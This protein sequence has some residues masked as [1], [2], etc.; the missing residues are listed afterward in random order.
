MHRRC[1]S[2]PLLKRPGKPAN[3]AFVQFYSSV[4]VSTAFVTKD[5]SPSTNNP[6]IHHKISNFQTTFIALR[7]QRSP[8]RAKDNG[9]KQLPGQFFL[10]HASQITVSPLIAIM[11][12]LNFCLMFFNIKQ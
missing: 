1:L 2:L 8:V 6:I 4:T 9:I 12:I 7:E 10:S 5:F 11:M 3:V